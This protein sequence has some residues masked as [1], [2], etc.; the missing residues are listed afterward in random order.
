MSITKRLL[1]SGLALVLLLIMSSAFVSAQGSNSLVRFAH[2]VPGVGEVDVYTNGQ[3]TIT[4]LGYGEGTGY[5]NVPAGDHE[6][7]VNLHGQ[8]TSL[9]SQTV[10][11]NDV[12]L[13][14]VASNAQ[15]PQFDAF[16]DNLAGMDVGQSR[17]TLLNTIAGS[18]ELNI[19]VNASP[20]S[21][22]NFDV[23]AGFY[24]L[25]ASTSAGA[26]LYSDV[27][28]NQHSG[29]SQFVILHGTPDAPDVLNLE[30]SDISSA[31]GL[32][33]FAHTVAGATDVDVY[34]DD[35]LIASGL[36][37]GSATPHLPLPAGTY[38]LDLRV[39]VGDDSLLQ[40]ELTVEDGVAVTAVALGTADSFEVSVFNDDLSGIDANTAVIAPINAIAG[41]SVVSY[42]LNDG[43]TIADGVGFGEAG[44]TVSIAPS[45]E[46]MPMVDFMVDG[47]SATLEQ[48]SMVF[49]GGVYYNAIAVTGS[50][51]SPPLLLF[52]PTNIAQGVASA[53]DM[54]MMMDMVEVP[55]VPVA[56][57]PEP[58]VTE[59]PVEAVA[60]EAPVVVAPTIPA[61]EEDPLP[62]ARI[63]LD[64]GVNLQLRQYPSSEA[65][66]LG[67][68]PSGSIIT[69]NGREGAPI[70][71]L[72][73]EELIAEGEE[74]FVDPASL[75]VDEDDDL[76]ADDTWVSIT[77]PTPDGGTITA[78]TIALY[79]D[80]RDD[81]NELVRLADLPTVPN[82][83]PGEASNTDVTPPSAQQ[84]RVTAEVINLDPSAN[85]N[86]RRNPDATSEVLAR[87]PVGTIVDLLG[88]LEE[89]RDWVFVS[90]SPAE[91][92]TIT[93]WV[94]T[95][96]IDYQL[97][98]EL[99]TVEELE[100]FGLLPTLTAETLG[101]VSA[102]A[103][104]VSQP[105]PD[106]EQDA[107]VAEVVLDAG[108]NLN[109]RRT[110][111]AQS[112]VVGRIPS[113][114]RLIITARTGDEDT[115]WLA[116]TF[117]G[118][119]GWVAADFVVISFNGEFVEDL[120]EIPAVTEE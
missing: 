5:I 65:L 78:W 113:G 46:E 91:G 83:I 80:I 93:G 38:N 77:Y 119:A 73:G 70:D 112:E 110:P 1:S 15:A 11:A 114:T 50:M 16:E 34:A 9:W 3:L 58:V 41:D 21:V 33:R 104:A 118:E 120:T 67:L 109:L 30:A 8:S 6:I 40:T 99:S 26:T 95:Q 71:I 74:P 43:T 39:A 107:Y 85:L 42:A 12:P 63:L 66:S 97:N 117:E 13:T 57:T 18:P 54:G 32:V 115:T 69:V 103:P 101:E 47:Q 49:Y 79:L 81:E 86:M 87:L 22:G 59:A 106:P 52:F 60:T 28:L 48:E 116:T 68:A 105:T 2:V 19:T 72:T 7:S 45:Y 56:S 25:S 37:F 53:P 64:P 31:G 44:D 36:T 92:G 102:G 24:T 23:P 76:I 14:L 89:T 4:N 82:N 10:S 84:D 17:L 100:G 75:L 27:P 111:D 61:T 51:F 35:V 94:S 88:I 62:T 55:D 29:V 108:A 20:I 96:F 98:G 90:F